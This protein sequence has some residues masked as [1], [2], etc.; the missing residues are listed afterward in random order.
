MRLVNYYK[1]E[2]DFI[3]CHLRFFLPGLINFM[4]G[5]HTCYEYSTFNVHS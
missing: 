2:E 4:L 1:M 3:F 5:K